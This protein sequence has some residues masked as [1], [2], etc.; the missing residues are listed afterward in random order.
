MFPGLHLRKKDIVP[1]TVLRGEKNYFKKSF[2]LHR[3]SSRH[4]SLLL[5]FDAWSNSPSH[6]RS[7][8]CFE[9]SDRA[10]R[11]RQTTPSE[12]PE[13]DLGPRTALT[14]QGASACRSAPAVRRKSH[15]S[16]GLGGGRARHRE[17][18]AAPA[19][20][21]RGDSE[22]VHALRRTAPL[23]RFLVSKQFNSPGVGARGP[24]GPSSVADC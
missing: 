2:I 22:S 7:R 11:T 12:I 18:G 1:E 5:P 23:T 17:R 13:A 21:I 9:Q 4:I 6:L 19:R 20:R 3:S 8:K 14:L 15:P 16:R 10:W 24:L